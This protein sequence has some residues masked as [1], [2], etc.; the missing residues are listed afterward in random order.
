M[1]E[2]HSVPWFPAWGVSMPEPVS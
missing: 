1:A 2:V